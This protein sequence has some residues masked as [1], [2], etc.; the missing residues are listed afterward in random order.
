MTAKFDDERCATLANGFAD[1]LDKS[2]GCLPVEA[3]TALARVTAATIRATAAYHD[4]HRDETIE[5]FRQGLLAAIEFLE[6][7]SDGG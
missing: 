3:L 5:G 7:Q 4:G 6:Q 1:V 2:T